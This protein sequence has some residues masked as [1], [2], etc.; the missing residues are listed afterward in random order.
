MLKNP[1]WVAATRMSVGRFNEEESRMNWVNN[2]WF[3]L[4][5]SRLFGKYLSMMLNRSGITLFLLSAVPL[6]RVSRW[7]KSSSGAG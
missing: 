4:T 7:A 5:R 6:H 1:G 3:G 2:S